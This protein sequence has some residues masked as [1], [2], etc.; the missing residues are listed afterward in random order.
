[1]KQYSIATVPGDGIG[2]E[3]CQAA[4]DV[5]KAAVPKERCASPNTAPAPRSISACNLSEAVPLA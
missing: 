3:V 4:V 2:P 1:M 5:L